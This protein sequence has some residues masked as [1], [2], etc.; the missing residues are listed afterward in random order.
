MQDSGSR[1]PIYE[2]IHKTGLPDA[3]VSK[4][5]DLSLTNQ[6]ASKTR[7]P[8]ALCSTQTHLQE[9][10]LPGRHVDEEACPL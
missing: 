4:Y 5:D 8:P 3:A 10:L 1:G 2:L 6:Y 7:S 9:N